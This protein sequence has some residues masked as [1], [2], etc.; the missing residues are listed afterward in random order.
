MNNLIALKYELK[1]LIITKKY[2]YMV[3]LL[4]LV[5]LDF[6]TRL[7]MDGSFGTAPFSEWSFTTYL[8][9][10]TPFLMI[11]LIVMS[12]HIFSEKEA[13]VRKILWTTAL[14]QGKYY[15][16]KA[17]ALF[18]ACLLAASVPIFTT[19][20]Y[21]G[22]VFKCTHYSIFIKPML[23]FL[24][25][26]CVLFL[27]GTLL[28]GKINGKLMYLLVPA[29]FI[30][31]LNFSVPVWTDVYGNNFLYQYEMISWQDSLSGTLPYILPKDFLI[32][33]LVLLGAG[34]AA[35]AFVCK[36]KEKND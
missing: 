7:L 10:F 3:L 2:F 17:A 5:T 9:M 32:S 19:F 11:M 34:I 4:V 36:V 31:A 13:K 20:I 27:G 33:R 15:L 23:I 28:I 1:R 35:L 12:T 24:L 8:S 26:P 14:S 22:I 29:A 30:L 16:L 25:P 6:L 18:T 21:Y